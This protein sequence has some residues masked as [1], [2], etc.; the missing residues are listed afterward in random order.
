V[1]YWRIKEKGISPY[2]M[3]P[4]LKKL[5]NIIPMNN[6]NPRYQVEE[7]VLVE[8]RNNMRP[9]VGIINENRYLYAK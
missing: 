9:I 1:S 8:L 7:R 2:T 3:A 4:S 5:I 6:G